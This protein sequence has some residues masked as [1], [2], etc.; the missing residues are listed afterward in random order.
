MDRNRFLKV[1][2][3]VIATVGACFYITVLVFY[4][5]KAAFLRGNHLLLMTVLVLLTKASEAKDNRF[6]LYLILILLPLLGF[7][8]SSIYL[9]DV[10]FR[11]GLFA[12]NLDLIMASFAIITVLLT[13]YFTIG[14]T[15][16]LLALVFFLYAF[17]G[18]YIPGPLGHGG[19]SIKR[20]L[21]TFYAYDGIQGMPTAVAAST[22]AMF[23]IFGSVLQ[24]TGVGDLFLSVAKVL[25][26]RSTGGAAKTAVVSSAF[27]GTI[28]GS[29]VANVLAT[30]TF[31]IPMMKKT[32]YSDVFAGAVEAVASTGGQIMPP[33]MASGAFVM[34]EMLGV[35]YTTIAR[36]AILPAILYFISAWM[37]V[38]LRSRKLGMTRTNVHES[39]QDKLEFRRV[40]PY[41]V[42]ILTLVYLLFIKGATPIRSAFWG[43]F[44]SAIVMML[45]GSGTPVEKARALI[46]ALQD[47][48]VSL[49]RIAP[50]CACAG[51]I[52]AVIGLTGL[53]TKIAGLVAALSGGSVIIALMLCMLVA[54][55]FGMGMPTTISYLLCS[56]ILGVALIGLGLEPIAAHLF[57]FYFAVFSGITPPVAIA[58]Y[59]AAGISGA[60]PLETG[61]QA[62][63]MV[64]PVLFIPYVFA[65]NPALLLIGSP[66][67]SLRCFLTALLGVVFMSFA[68]EGWAL[69]KVIT[70]L[71]RML[72]AIVS[73]LLIDSR[74]LTDIAGLLLGIGIV[75]FQAWI[76]HRLHSPERS[77]VQETN[78]MDK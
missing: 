45:Y 58:A 19:Y 41:L 34:A 47:G 57:I 59:A 55:V 13:T 2:I 64:L 14:S 22:L 46:T 60:K 25:T 5:T 72:Y 3:S 50:V 67:E 53:G 62:L 11:G 37:V 40:F 27:F 78:F 36:S 49:S 63:K 61:F 44:T 52:G 9:D 32:G 15:L 42:P 54:I 24:A 39:N 17:C 16:P 26:K 12:S 73:V 66:L 31:T 6:I 56:T 30:G 74:G 23:I 48:V 7:S 35:P 51:M 10:I 4:P 71:T 77:G 33:I 18:K 20:I 28:S 43:T 76:N 65:L 38:D 21:V 69:G 70:P 8:Y 68:T 1:I 29:A 75:V